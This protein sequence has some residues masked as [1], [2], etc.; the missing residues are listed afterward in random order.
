MVTT[1]PAASLDD[2][3]QSSF[4]TVNSEWECVCQSVQAKLASSLHINRSERE[5][6]LLLRGVEVVRGE[7]ETNTASYK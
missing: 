1:H 6:T 4:H 3:A 5:R 7:A 2:D